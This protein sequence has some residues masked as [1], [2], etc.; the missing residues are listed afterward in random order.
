MLFR[1]VNL[2]QNL[3]EGDPVVSLQTLDPIYV[4]FSLPQQN[5]SVL[6]AGGAVRLTSDAAPGE[7]FE[8]RI[9]AVNPDVDA[10]T[11]NVRLQATLANAAEKLRPGM[12]ATVTVVLAQTETVRVIPTSA[13]LYAPYGDSVFVIDEKK[14][15]KT[16]Q[17]EKVL[18]QQFVRLGTARGDF[19]AVSS[20]L[21]EGEQIVTS[22]VFKLRPGESVV[23]DNTLAPDAKLAPKPTNS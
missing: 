21:K 4:N 23:I 22:G 7:T 20:G 12:F 13:V 17:A 19:V 14:N 2:G 8:G 9:N 11:R 3:K 18:R 10:I 15:D 16:G 6:A 1:S 5:M